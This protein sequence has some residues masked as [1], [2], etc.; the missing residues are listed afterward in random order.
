MAARLHMHDDDDVNQD[1]TTKTINRYLNEP[2]VLVKLIK[3]NNG[4]RKKF[5]IYFAFILKAACE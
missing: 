5:F 3:I 1:Q 2:N 4:F